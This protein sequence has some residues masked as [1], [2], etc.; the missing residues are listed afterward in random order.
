MKE[1]LFLY[2]GLI[3]AITSNMLIGSINALINGKFDKYKFCKGL[4]KG[5]V[6]TVV[7]ILL[8]AAGLLN[9]NIKVMDDLTIPLAIEV[10]TLSAF[11]FY[12][13]QALNKVKEIM[14]PSKNVSEKAKDK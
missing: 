3:L 5:L 14:L 10:I 11:I 12:T 8:M 9:P 1:L 7:L 4:T 13:A 6:I 2:I